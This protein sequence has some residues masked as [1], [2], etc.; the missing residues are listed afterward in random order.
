M[1]GRATARMCLSFICIGSSWTWGHRK[2]GE[3]SGDGLGHTQRRRY[4]STKTDYGANPRF[5]HSSECCSLT[6]CARRDFRAKLPLRRLALLEEE[7]RIQSAQGL[8][9][10]AKIESE[11]G[12]ANES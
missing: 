12:V 6:F 4:G 10:I 7:G 1:E 9:S 3:V 2:W 8:L 11:S 5:L